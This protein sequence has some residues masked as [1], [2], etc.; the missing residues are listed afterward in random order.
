MRKLALGLILF[1]F[2]LPLLGLAEPL[3]A[4]GTED[5]LH[6]GERLPLWSA[7]PFVGILLSIAVLPLVAPTFWHHHFPKISAAWALIFAIPFLIYYKSEALHEILHIYFLDY[8]P[9]IILLWGLFTIAGGIYVKGSMQG[10]P[11]IN[12]ILILIGTL[13]ASWVGTT[14]AAMI[15]IRPILR[16]NENRKYK[17]HI[18]VFFIFLVANIGGTLT[19]LG[20]PPLFLGFLHGVSFF[21]TLSLFPELLVTAGL[22]LVIFYLFDMF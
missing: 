10:T 18:I 2:L 19:P 3:L 1:V 22:L 13:L 9:F 11:V 4:S 17:I 15:M 20:D 12:T 7:I 16:A 21:W 6:L 14:G 5:G 8:I